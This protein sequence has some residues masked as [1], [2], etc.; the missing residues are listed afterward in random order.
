VLVPRGVDPAAIAAQA[1]PRGW[2][3]DESDALERIRAEFEK[4]VDDADPTAQV[5]ARAGAESFARQR[6]AARIQEK[7]NR[8][9]G[10]F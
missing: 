4:H 2:V 5:V 8:V 1:Y 3:G 6:D 10:L 9:R 7:A